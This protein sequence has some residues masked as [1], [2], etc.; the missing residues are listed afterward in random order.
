[1]YN[2]VIIFQIQEPKGDVTITN[3]GATILQ[4]MKLAHPAAKMVNYIYLFLACTD[5]DL[6]SSR[7]VPFKTFVLNVCVPFLY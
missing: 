3:D 4:Q 1:M 2:L 7:V 6:M 5:N